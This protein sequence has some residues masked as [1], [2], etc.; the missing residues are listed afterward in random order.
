MDTQGLSQR[1][2]QDLIPCPVVWSVSPALPADYQIDSVTGR[3]SG[4][5][6]SLALLQTQTTTHTFR[7][8]P[9]PDSGQC[10]GLFGNIT[11]KSID[12]VIHPFHAQRV[13][14]I[15]PESS[16]TADDAYTFAFSPTAGV[17]S[18]SLAV[19]LVGELVDVTASNNR[20]PNVEL[21]VGVN[22]DGSTNRVVLTA[23]ANVY[24][25]RA[26]EG[27][28]ACADCNHSGANTVTKQILFDGQTLQ[29]ESG[30]GPTYVS[31]SGS[32]YY[33]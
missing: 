27:S 28:T 8:S 11:E 18:S 2:T 1:L 30:T 22:N 7:A 5:A 15:A 26:P 3:V 10:I 23:G 19:D 16:D 21:F 4:G 29:R 31:L 20:T 13:R 14:V 25:A 9:D 24:A 12:L 17:V 32:F 33:P 6:Q